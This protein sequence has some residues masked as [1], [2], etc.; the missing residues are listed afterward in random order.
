MKIEGFGN[1]Y[2]FGLQGERKNRAESDK[3]NSN[4]Q[5]QEQSTGETE[6]AKNAQVHRHHNHAHGAIRN[7][8]EAH[9]QGVAS[10]RLQINFQ[11]KIQTNSTQKLND[12][13][14]TGSNQLV[15]DLEVQVVTLGNDFQGSFGET[16]IIAQMKGLMDTFSQAVSNLFGG[17]EETD[18]TSIKTA[19]TQ[20]GYIFAGIQGA[21]G[22]FFNAMW[23]IGQPPAD[24]SLVVDTD[25]EPVID[26]E[27]TETPVI[28]VSTADETEGTTADIATEEVVDEIVAAA[29]TDDPENTPVG[30]SFTD[31]LTELQTWFDSQIASLQ[32]SVDDLM[33][34]PP[35]SDQRGHGMAYSRFLAIY[36]EMNSTESIT[37][38]GDDMLFDGGLETEA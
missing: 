8:Q 18:S 5:R 17:S 3:E 12:V 26:P 27:N 15:T 25:M 37:Q 13:L 2:A 34:M 33:K 24:E 10:L 38:T 32:T 35:I 16:D 31:K 28:A 20:P 29:V 14:V 22:D 1:R 30:P 6:Q 7:L 23:Q 4:L 36:T 11:E 19:S 21:F 9:F